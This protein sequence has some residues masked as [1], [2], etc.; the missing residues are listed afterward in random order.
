MRRKRNHK[1]TQTLS[2]SHALLALAFL[3]ALVLGSI[4]SHGGSSTNLSSPKHGSAGTSTNLTSS[5]F[6]LE[7]DRLQ[8]RH[9]EHHRLPP[10]KFVYIANESASGSGS[11]GMSGYTIDADTGTLSPVSGACACG[12]AVDG[13][14]T[15]TL[16]N[17]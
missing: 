12:S 17:I 10:P 13:P 2:A 15:S 14:L 7:K 4:S 16:S 5:L 3:G 1:G 8:F 6:R 9:R 11:Y